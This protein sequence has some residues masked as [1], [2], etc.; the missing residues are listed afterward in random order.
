MACSVVSF[1]DESKRRK[2]RGSVD[3]ILPAFMSRVTVRMIPF[4]PSR[5]IPGWMLMYFKGIV[6]C[7]RIVKK[8]KI[9][10]IHARS[11]I[12]AM[13]AF[14]IKR[15]IGRR[16]K[17]IYDYR[18]V[19]VD[20][21]IYMGRWKKWSWKSRCARCVESANLAR[22]DR[23]VAVSNVMRTYLLEEHASNAAE[24][25]KKIHVIPNKTRVFSAQHT[26]NSVRDGTG[27]FIGVYSGS[28]A[29]W[30]GIPEMIQ[31]WKTSAE[32][33]RQFSF[34]LLT[35]DNKN[36][37][38]YRFQNDQDLLRRIQII[39]LR[40][41]EVAGQ[42]SGA[43]FGILLRE[44]HLVNRVASPLKFAEYLASGLPVVVSEGI[45]DTEEIIEKFRVGI[46][47]RDRNY[48]LALENLVELL[49]DGSLRQRCYDVARKEFN[50]EDAIIDYRNLYSNLLETT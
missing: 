6:V 4:R 42:L 19:F 36:Q 22:A 12:P 17:V 21:Q 5:L 44:K 26:G 33:F 16:V 30:Q 7:S 18:G 24:L 48:H 47:V 41:N 27:K 37:F 49:K 43:D 40:P 45:G 46:I 13:I 25:R 23:I 1:E 8:S 31:F 15:S 20:E 3:S 28:A 50:L 11:L 34:K 39:Q 2:T 9:D 14:S 32:D 35:Y 38:L 29:A 10:I